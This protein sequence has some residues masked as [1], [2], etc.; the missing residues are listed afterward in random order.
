M[1]SSSYA[2]ELCSPKILSIVSDWLAASP[3]PETLGDR[4]PLKMFNNMPIHGELLAAFIARFE[5]LATRKPLATREA[6]AIRWLAG[7]RDLKTMKRDDYKGEC[8]DQFGISGRC[9]QFR[10]WPAARQL[11]G[12][13][14]R[15][16]PGPKKSK[17]YFLSSV[18]DIFS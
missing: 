3:F 15:A 18:R 2:S 13:T 12:L 5:S 10:V 6:E 1:T 14:K 4:H 7:K 8:I 17:K 9:Y 16:K 11:A